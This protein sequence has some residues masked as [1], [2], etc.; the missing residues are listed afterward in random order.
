M[1]QLLQLLILSNIIFLFLNSCSN[2]ASTEVVSLEDILPTSVKYSEETLKDTTR[3]YKEPKHSHDTITNLDKVLYE[4]FPELKEEI[5][6]TPERFFVDRLRPLAKI[7]KTLKLDSTQIHLVVWNFKDSI[8]TENAFFNW[9]DN[10]GENQDEIRVGDN[11]RY[12]TQGNFIYVGEVDLIYAY[13]AD[14]FDYDVIDRLIN[15]TYGKDWKYS[16]QQAKGKRAKWLALPED[17]QS[18]EL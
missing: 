2:E 5:D 11:F 17:A 6:L 8:Q 13:A 16:V 14:S 12:K 1:K 10:F 15:Q 9:L 18:A 4:Q 3:V 7:V